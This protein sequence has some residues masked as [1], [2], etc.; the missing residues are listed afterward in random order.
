MFI[1]RFL[2]SFILWILIWIPFYILGFLVGWIGLIFCK[3]ES[4]HMPWLWWPWDN[5]AHGINGTLSGN[6]P[7]WVVI[8][9]PEAFPPEGGMDENYK[10]LQKIVNE[11]TGKERTFW[12]RWVWLI[13]RNPVSNLSLDWLGAKITKPVKN[14]YFKKFNGGSSFALY[15]SG[16]FWCYVL[17]FSY[18]NNKGFYH[19]FGWKLLDLTQDEKGGTKA[20][21]MFRISPLYTG[22]V[23]AL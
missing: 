17:F 21:F 5:K 4:E 18:S 10:I 16:I 15:R 1:L 8:C 12:K 22:K 13:W 20:R 3:R 7:K 2:A 23:A 19:V 14:V 6:N 9:N 11:K